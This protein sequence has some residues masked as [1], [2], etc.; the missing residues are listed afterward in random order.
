[1]LH[2]KPSFV[3]E[4]LN[5]SEDFLRNSATTTK[6]SREAMHL[7]RVDGFLLF[8]MIMNCLP[9]LGLINDEE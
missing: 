8:M 5:P 3:E 2:E 1:V 4:A 7:N 6:R 9:F